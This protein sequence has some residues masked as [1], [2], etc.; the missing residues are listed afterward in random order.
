METVT[1]T[2]TKSNLAAVKQGF[3]DFATGDFQS[4]INRCTDDVVWGSYKNPDVPI[5]GFYY[6]KEGV[7]EFFFMLTKLVTLTEFEPKE[8]I[9]ENENVVVLGRQKGTVNETGK[10]F[11]HD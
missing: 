5:S 9:A 2:S 8:F 10:T 6:G 4:I 11:E 1:S 7:H 3:T